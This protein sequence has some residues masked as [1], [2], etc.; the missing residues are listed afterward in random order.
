MYGTRRGSGLAVVE[1]GVATGGRGG[2]VASGW[3][4]EFFFLF[5][6][7]LLHQGVIWYQGEGGQVNYIA[8]MN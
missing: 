1:S 4:L 8:I 6:L 2:G 7:A 3:F 5:F